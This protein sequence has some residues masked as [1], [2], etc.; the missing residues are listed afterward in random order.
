MHHASDG[1]NRD[2]RFR[3]KVRHGILA[4]FVVLVGAAIVHIGLL[5]SGAN[6]RLEALHA[7]GQPTSLAEWAEQHRLPQGEENAAGLYEEAFAMLHDPPEDV[8]IPLLGH[9]RLPDRGVAWPED[10]VEDT[11]SF[12]A[13]NQPCLDRL[14]AATRIEHCWYNWECLRS[15]PSFR[16]IRQ[17]TRLLELEMRYRAQRSDTKG[18]LAS[19]QAGL[20]LS[21]SLRNEPMMITY[22]TRMSCITM[23]LAGLE[24]SLSVAPFTDEQLCELEG[25]LTS[26]ATGLD[27][28][29]VLISEQ[30]WAIEMYRDPSLFAREMGNS[31]V[32]GLPGVKK[33]GLLDTLDHLANCIEASKLPPAQRLARF[34]E[35]D[36]G[37]S[38]LS[39]LHF[40]MKQ[41]SRLESR[42]I[43]LD[44]R[45]LG[46]LDLALAAL[47][48]ERYR[49]ATGDVP[50]QLDELVP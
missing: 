39:V 32:F 11:A 9:M 24:R 33:R 14:H 20:H 43:S 47:A 21:E 29:T 23:L 3:P 18:A 28:T 10:T 8:N 6:R 31:A 50:E 42:L 40:A 17:C 15:L 13:N 45:T 41:T 19:F 36:E 12:L 5:S 37:L 16:E 27:V 1:G 38:R 49:L 7:A 4:V 34:H 2:K 46:N 48:I 44:L 22:L 30:C 26:T 25:M 35:I